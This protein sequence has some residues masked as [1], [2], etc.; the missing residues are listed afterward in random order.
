METL[1]FA[2][3]IFIFMITVYGTLVA[4]GEVLRRKAIDELP[5]D[6]T[7][8]TDESGVDVLVGSDTVDLGGSQR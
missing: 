8:V 2:V 4:G 1:L 6:V 7:V 3:G 5:D